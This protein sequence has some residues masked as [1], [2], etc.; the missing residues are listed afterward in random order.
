MNFRRYRLV[1][2]IIVIFIISNN[3]LYSQIVKTKGTSHVRVEENITEANTRE[4]AEQLAIIN[5]IENAFGTYTEQQTDMT[6]RDGMTYY[7]IIGT[8]K[9]KGDWIETIKVDFIENFKKEKRDF[10]ISN[11]KYITCNIRGKARKSKPKANLDIEILNHTDIH[12]RTTKFYDKEPLYVWFRSPVDGYLSIFLEDDNAVYR[13]LPYVGMQSNFQS[14]VP[15]IADKEY[16]L[17]SP[18]NNEFTGNPVDELVMVLG[19][20]NI[21]YNNI[22]VIFSQD[23]YVKPGLKKEDKRDDGMI[24]PRQLT[25]NEFTE[26]L[27]ENRV[28]SQSFQELKTKISISKNNK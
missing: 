20:K 6:I 8:T 28:F 3:S 22:Y 4:K 17:F 18:D 23:K 27:I 1:Y 25:K 14:G 16:M 7:N 19:D 21:E 2:S 9:V 24:T 13:L 12:A 15:V 26:W 10:G 11:V 5:A